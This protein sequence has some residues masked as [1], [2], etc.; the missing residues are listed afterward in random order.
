[1]NKIKAKARQDRYL[2]SEKGKLA[3]QRKQEKY[4]ETFKGRA[5][6]LYASAKQRAKKRKL[7]FTITQK[8]VEDRLHV[9]NKTCEVTGTPLSFEKHRTAKSN[10]F[11]PSL[12]QKVVGKGY[13]PENIQIVAF[14]YTRMKSDLTDA[15]AKQILLE[16]NAGMQRN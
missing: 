14:W 4:G 8:I 3:M 9:I 5:F 6:V 13:T 1:M 15:E 10:P 16:C 7:P 11:A 12:D 2:K